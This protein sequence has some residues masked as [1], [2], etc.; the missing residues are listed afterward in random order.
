MP[1]LRVNGCE[2]D[3]EIA[4][5]GPAVVLVHGEDHGIE[6]FRYLVAELRD[7]YTCL[8]YHR[9]GHGRSELARYGYSVWNQ[10]VDLRALLDA[11]AIERAAI[12]AVAM[13]NTIALSFAVAHPQRVRGLAMAS[14]YE[15]DGY[16]LLEQRRRRHGMSFAEL[17]LDM[18]AVIS[19]RG[20]EGLI[21]YLEQG[22]DSYLPIFPR[23]LQ[24]RSEVIRMFASHPPGHY[25][26]AAEMYT[27]IPHLTPR[28]AELRCPILGVCGDEDPSPDDPAL[29]AH[30]PNFRQVWIRGARRFT[31]LERPAEFNAA[32]AGFLDQLG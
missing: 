24:L 23:D 32:I 7:R 8:A 26:A 28:L 5:S 4:G 9:R 13:G 27:S 30:L 29:T 19:A 3:Y 2:F 17:H 16:P 25:V 31:M 22:G 15:L 10:A 11:L 20:R 14:W 6:Y 12:V 18:H 1:A 21:D